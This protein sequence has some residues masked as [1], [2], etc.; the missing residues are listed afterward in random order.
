MVLGNLG[1]AYDIMLNKQATKRHHG[2]YKIMKTMQKCVFAL[3]STV[4]LQQQSTFQI[5][6]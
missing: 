2:M 3:T 6:V 1:N 5:S 4:W